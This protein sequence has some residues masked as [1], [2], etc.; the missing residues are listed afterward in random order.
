MVRFSRFAAGGL[1][2]GGAGHD[3][4]VQGLHAPTVLNEAHGQPIKQFGM[5]GQFA[6]SAEIVRCRHNAFSKVTLPNAVYDYPGGEWVFLVCDP[7][8][9]GA[10][11]P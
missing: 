11:T 10:A 5:A 6:Q 4:L 7:L 8:G 2:I 1:P 3:E 9:Q